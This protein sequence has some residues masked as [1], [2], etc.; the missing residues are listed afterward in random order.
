MTSHALL[1]D[2]PVVVEVDVAWGDMDAFAHVNNTMYF[3]YFETA[4]IAFLDR[5]AFRGESGIGPILASTHCRFRR[6]LTYPDA[7]LVGARVSEI[8]DDRFTHEYRLVSRSLDE[9][10]AEGGGVVV[11]YDYGRKTRCDIP[12]DVRARMESL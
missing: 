9:V 8:G 5:I 11:A 2:Y 7:V 6:P 10:A 4:R 12:A 1:A 3:R